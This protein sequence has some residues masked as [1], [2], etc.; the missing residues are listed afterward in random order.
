[1]TLR[2]PEGKPLP[3]WEP[4]APIELMLDTGLARTYSL[5]GDPADLDR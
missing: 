4:G 3:D 2:H 1:M 5:C